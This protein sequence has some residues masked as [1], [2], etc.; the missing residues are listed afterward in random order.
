MSFLTI[1]IIPERLLKLIEVNVIKFE[2][3]SFKKIYPKI[4]KNNVWVCIIKLVF[5][6]VVFVHRKNITS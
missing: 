1:K 2:I 3:F 6:T 4:A 5:A